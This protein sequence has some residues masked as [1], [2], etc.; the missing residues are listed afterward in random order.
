MKTGWTMAF[1]GLLLDSHTDVIQLWRQRR[2]IFVRMTVGNVKKSGYAYISSVNESG[3][4]HELGRLSLSLQGTG[5][6]YIE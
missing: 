4:L 3:T 2:K 5:P 1:E 6:L